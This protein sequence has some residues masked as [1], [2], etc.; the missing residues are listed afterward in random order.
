MPVKRRTPKRRTN[1]AAELEAWAT[2]FDCGHDFFNELPRI[3]VDCERSRGPERA[4]AEEAWHR[5]GA[6]Y[7]A[8]PEPKLK[9]HSELWALKEFGEPHAG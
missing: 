1:L 2:Y 8:D 6:R 9:P 4:V 3:G 5:L 7:L